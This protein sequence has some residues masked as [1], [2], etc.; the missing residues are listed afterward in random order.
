MHDLMRVY[1]DRGAVVC[2]AHLTERLPPGVVHSYE[3]SAVYDPVGEPGNS[4]DRGGCVNQ[5]TPR[6]SIAKNVSGTAAN[7]CLV[8]VE[9]WDGSGVLKKAPETPGLAAVAP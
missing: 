5:L 9:L 2:A 6:R 8:E 3:S 4:V 1:N 7:S